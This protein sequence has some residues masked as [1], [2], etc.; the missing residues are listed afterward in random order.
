MAMSFS[1]WA[2]AAIGT[3]AVVG[4]VLR[5]MLSRPSDAFNAGEVSQSWLTEHNAGKNDSH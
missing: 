1:L 3:V 2:A 5:S 4:L